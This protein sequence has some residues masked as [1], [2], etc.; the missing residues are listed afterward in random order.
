MKINEIQT[1]GNIRYWKFSP[2]GECYINVPY[3]ERA[4]MKDRK[5]AGEYY[6]GGKTTTLQYI[7]DCEEIDMLLD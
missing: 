1:K 6:K 3:P 5:I 7:V 4:V 2:Q